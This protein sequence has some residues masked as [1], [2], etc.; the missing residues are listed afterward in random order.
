MIALLIGRLEGGALEMDTWLM[1]CRV[2]GRGVEEACLNLL[3]AGA[4]AHGAERISGDYRP[5]AK[6]GMVRELYSRLGFTLV[7]RDADGSTR[8]SLDLTQWTPRPVIMRVRDET[9]AD[10]GP[11]G[12]KIRER[13]TGE[14]PEAGA[15]ESGDGTDRDLQQTY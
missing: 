6:N 14:A 9:A 13:G 3:A 8:W 11:S 1:S 4:R 15:H 7:S 10:G 5:T 2:L 12:G